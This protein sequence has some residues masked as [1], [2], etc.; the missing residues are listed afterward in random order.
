MVRGG[1]AA[2]GLL[3]AE[4]RSFGPA[5]GGASG[6]GGVIGPQ[7]TMASFH[8][9]VENPPLHPFTTVHPFTIVVAG[10]IY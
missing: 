5:G 1:A 7:E 10:L 2:T 6:R 4:R 8:E 3:P 9:A